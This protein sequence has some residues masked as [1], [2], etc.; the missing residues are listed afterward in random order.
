MEGDEGGSSV[1]RRQF[2]LGATG[3][4]VAAAGA[5]VAGA[6]EGNETGGNES[7]GNESGAGADGNATG[8]SAQSGGGG[9]E[10][11]ELVDYAFEPATEDPLVIAPGTTVT[12]TW[13]TDNHNIVVES[14]PEASDWEG[15]EPIENSGF[16]T[17]HTFDAEGTY[18]FYCQPHESLGMVGTIEVTTEAGGGEAGAEGGAGSILPESAQTIGIATT[19]A[20]VSV[21]GLAYFF[22]KYGG[23][24][25]DH[26]EK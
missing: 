1:S 3:G 12:F 9:S 15:H 23:D 8:A 24:Y 11:V 26:V 10:T 22:M 18:E 17:E 25:G 19:G 6:Q 5:G 7:D 16:E 21:L 14:K 20:L 4:A 2:V 13:V